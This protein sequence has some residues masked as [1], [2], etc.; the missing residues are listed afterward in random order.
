TRLALLRYPTPQG[1]DQRQVIMLA[2]VP[3]VEGRMVKA[4][5]AQAA[6]LLFRIAEI[7]H[8]GGQIL[9]IARFEK[10]H[11]IIIEVILVN[12]RT[13]YQDRHP[14][15]HELQNLGAERLVSKRVG[16]LGNNSQISSRHDFGNL[17]D[18]NAWM[19]EHPVRNPQLTG[20]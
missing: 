20:Q 15:G 6:P 11:Q 13:R 4:V 8:L 12:P 17:R 1:I 16:P 14:G 9:V 19:E 7:N 2:H 18:W 5:L 3:T 10:A